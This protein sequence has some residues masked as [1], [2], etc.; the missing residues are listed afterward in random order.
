LSRGRRAPLGTWFFL[1]LFGLA[2]VCRILI[3]AFFG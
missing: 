3:D 2:G 1:I